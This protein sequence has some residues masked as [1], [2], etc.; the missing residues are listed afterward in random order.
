M[1]FPTN[2]SI[3]WLLSGAVAAAIIGGCSGMEPGF[4]YTPEQFE[5]VNGRVEELASGPLTKYFSAQS[6]TTADR[7]ALETSVPMVDEMIRF[8]P[9]TINSYSLKGKLLLALGETDKAREA[10]L[11]GIA[12]TIP[13]EENPQDDMVR[14][15]VLVGL[16][17]I[18]VG[19]GEFDL[20]EQAAAQALTL[21]PDSAP[22]ETI[23]A[24][25][26]L[27]AK[28]YAAAKE[29]VMRALA[30]ENDYEPAR[31]LLRTIDSESRQAASP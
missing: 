19:A 7:K 26:R 10:F 30:I 14:A 29:H 1:L 16:A 31:V 27:N 22:A 24:Q 21:Y 20:A 13:R 3:S 5:A 25:A 8:D 12:L 4:I 15:D 11:D 17:Q 28:D 9:I 23:I 18:H 6:L 2:W